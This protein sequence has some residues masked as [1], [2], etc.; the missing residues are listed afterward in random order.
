MPLAINRKPSSVA[1]AALEM[2]RTQIGVREVP[3]GSNA[4]P[5]VKQYLASVDLPTGYAWCAAFVYWCNREACKK[6]GV[7][8]IV[9]KTGGVLNMFNNAKGACITKI[10]AKNGAINPD[11]VRPGDIFV[12]QFKGGVGH[13]GFVDKISG[14]TIIT[15][16]G[17]TD[18]A[19]GRE[20]IGVF[21]KRRKVSVMR[22]FIRVTD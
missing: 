10:D 2:A 19:G 8:N 15:I 17:N 7:P 13:I 5:Q 16:E 9:P 20:G 22:G 11:A 3:L 12:M 14:D 21:S 18:P 6:L 1:L 4:G